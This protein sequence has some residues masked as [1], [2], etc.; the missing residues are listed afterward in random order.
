MSNHTQANHKIN[1]R[2]IIIKPKSTPA[3]T[4]NKSKSSETTKQTTPCIRPTYVKT[5][6][7]NKHQSIPHP[8]TK[9]VNHANKQTRKQPKQC[10]LK[11]TIQ[12][13]HH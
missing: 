3:P 6:Y 4:T 12:L 7:K 9:T 10:K 2:N 13:H 11:H 8:T 1:I 5:K